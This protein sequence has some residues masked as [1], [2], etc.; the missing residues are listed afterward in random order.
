MARRRTP[1]ALQAAE[2]AVAVP[3]VMAHRFEQM[4]RAGA[5]PGKHDLAENLR[6]G[7]EK[8]SAGMEAWK[9]FATYG[10]SLQ[11][12]M[13][14]E[15]MRATSSRARSPVAAWASWTS[16]CLGAMRGMESVSAPFHRRAVANSRRLGGKSKRR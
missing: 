3:Q 12:A 10:W 4:A 15:M 9:A 7:T 1:L 5:H 8:F 16:M 13:F 2:L 14:R 11:Q 6:M